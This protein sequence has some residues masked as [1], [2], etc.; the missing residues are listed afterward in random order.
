MRDDRRRSSAAARRSCVGKRDRQ[1]SQ[2]C[3][4]PYKRKACASIASAD[5]PAADRRSRPLAGASRL[6]EHAASACGL[7]APP[8]H[9]DPCFLA[10]PANAARRV[11]TVVG[12]ER[13]RASPHHPRRRISGKP[14]AWS[15]IRRRRCDRATSA[16]SDAKNGCVQHARD[17]T[18]RRPCR[19]PRRR[20][21][22]RSDA[23]V[24]AAHEVV[25]QRIARAG[26]AGNAD[27]GCR[28]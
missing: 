24:R 11:A 9:D 18:P 27:R 2:A 4:P 17:R 15:P 21:C 8:P 5:Q 26:V 19:A 7:R 25:D 6:A 20:R 1:S 23:P 10:F 14:G 3:A 13:R 22:R 28:R 16:A 12:R